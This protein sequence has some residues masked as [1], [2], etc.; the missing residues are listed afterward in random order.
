MLDISDYHLSIIDEGDFVLYRGS[1]R[2]DFILVVVPSDDEPSARSLACLQNE[3]AIRDR[4]DPRRAALPVGLTRWSDKIALVLHD[5]GGVPLRASCGGGLATRE[6]LAAAISLAEAVKAL[7]DNELIHGGIRPANV[8]VRM[9]GDDCWA[10]LTGFGFTACALDKQKGTDALGA[11]RGAFAYLAPEQTGRINRAVDA[12]SDLYAL[13]C[14]FYE[15]LTGEPPFAALDP[16]T[17]IHSHVARLPTPPSEVVSSVPPQISSIVMKLLAKTPEGRYQTV[18]GL[19]DDLLRCQR[20]R[21][22]HGSIG[23]FALDAYDIAYR[24]KRLDKLYGRETEVSTLQAAFARTIEEGRAEFVFVSGYSGAGKSTLVQA[25]GNHV[26]LAGYAF[27]AGKCDPVKRTIPY[28][29]F[30]QA[31]RDLV[32]FV[33]AQEESDFEA[34]RERLLQALGPNA[35]ILAALAPDLELIV[36]AHSAPADLPPPAEKARFLRTAARLIGAF[37]TRERPLVLFLDDVQWV[38]RGSWAV[39]EYL[40]T[41][42]EIRHF[43]L[44]AAYRDNEVDSAHPVWR[45]LESAGAPIRSLRLAPLRL[46]DLAK[47]VAETLQC[48]VDEAMPLAGLISEKTGGDP[49]FTVQFLSTLADERLVAFN[50][51][52][53]V[54]TWNLERIR[55]KGYADNVIDLMLGKVDLLS[56]ETRSMLER[57]ACLGTRAACDTLSAAAGE[58]EERVHAVLEEACRVNLVHQ[59]NDGYSFWHDRIQETV[60]ASIDDVE[61]DARHLEIGR[62]LL[63]L[64]STAHA[65]DRLF[66]TV[67]QINR[68]AALVTVAEERRQ[69]ARLNLLAGQRAKSATAYSCALVYLTT[70][71]RLIEGNAGIEFDETAHAIELHRAECEFLT[72]AMQ[73][74]EA[75]FDALSRRPIALPLRA[76]LTRLRAALYITVDRPKMAL[77]VGLD[78]CRQ[79]GMHLPLHPADDDVDREHTRVLEQLGGQ[80]IED[81]RDLPAMHEPAWIGAMNVLADLVPAALFTDVNLHDL[82]RLRMINLSLEYGHCDASC[83]AYVCAIFGYRYADYDTAFKLG[84]LARDLINEK[85]M[86]RFKARVEMSFGALVLPWKRPAKEGQAFMKQALQIAAESGDLTFEA[87]SH[88]NLLTNLIFAGEPID[89]MQAAAEK[90]FAFAKEKQFVL[91]VD[92]LLAQLLMFRRLR[93]VSEGDGSPADPGYDERWVAHFRRAAT[94]HRAIA[95]FAFWTHVLTTRVLF[96]DTGG[97]IEAE[98]AAG[99]LYC[100]SRSFLESADF[101]FYGSLA[102]AAAWRLAPENEKDTHL[103]AL[104]VHYARL[105]TWRKTCAENFAGR[106]ALVEAELARNEGRLI[107]AECLYEEAIQHARKQEFVHNEALASELAGQ[108]YADRGFDTIAGA[109]LRNAKH[110]YSLWG[111]DAKVKEFDCRYFQMRARPGTEASG[112]WIAGASPLFDIGTVVKASQALSGEMVLDKLVETLMAISLEHALACRCLLILSEGAA[113]AIRAEAS[114]GL[115]PIEVVLR[116]DPVNGEEL[117][118]S[119]V[120][121]VARTLNSVVLDD[122]TSDSTFAGDAYFR[123]RHARSVLCVPLVKQAKL[124]GILYMENELASGAFTAERTSILQLIASQAAISIENARLYADLVEENQRRESAESALRE[125]RAALEHA[126]RLTTMGELVASIVH[127]INQPLSSMATCA[128]AGLRWLQRETPELAEACAMFERIDIDSTR[129]ADVIHALRAMAR[130]AVPER[131]RFDINEAIRQVLALTAREL[132]DRGIVLDA[133]RIVDSREACGD[134]IQLQQVILNLV[135]NAVEAMADVTDRARSLSL[136]TDRCGEGGVLVRVVDTGCGIDPTFA[137][138]IL[139]PFVTTKQ[140]GMGM[141]LSICRSIVESHGG[142]LHFISLEPYG[143]AFEFTIPPESEKCGGEQA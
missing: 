142:R 123:R 2:D 70:A 79:V 15:M 65:G 50:H 100:S 51:A 101:H 104:K 125:A 110:A 126:A 58:P 107:D 108:F 63:V 69:F 29:S 32:R 141:G 23:A 33:L 121:T 62:R 61:R 41:H 4:L 5:P 34:S 10:W 128:N 21:R 136:S 98:T 124:V 6:F 138:R 44:V 52:Q 129:A 66:E 130:K 40:L 131:T 76:E 46:D 132:K 30:A 18:D 73:A 3:L 117:P 53:Q 80:T 55:A 38:D 143:T 112:A 102:R 17:C 89:H 87:Y 113:L 91:V 93:G 72:G 106:A 24:L 105:C 43:L 37:A 83:Y 118:N 133:S 11:T 86:T 97:A 13:G 74:A 45:T 22:E 64:G 42:S 82:V 139:Q 99:G 114:I 71:E 140:S 67:N 27:A 134:R 75:R 109:Y 8:L 90:G 119:L 103:S 95:A 81:L 28:A 19:L 39:V 115:G 12:R 59:V 36:G 85:R 9:Q 57:L 137:S 122:A 120:Q 84:E 116:H 47:L 68:G 31:L 49:F 92:A 88:R 111:A 35:A 26:R 25:F 94:S 135:M 77:E 56:E 127:E 7:H 54:W 1:R 16:M 60:Y 14:T 48:R 96:G 78:F 20:V